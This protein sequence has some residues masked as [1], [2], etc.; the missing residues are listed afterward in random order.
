LQRRRA[1][2]HVRHRFELAVAFLFERRT[3]AAM[4]LVEVVVPVAVEFFEPVEFEV[5][6]LVVLQWRV[7][8][9]V[10]RWRLVRLTEFLFEFEERVL[11]QRLLD[12][13]LKVGDRQLQNFHRLDHARRQNLA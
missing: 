11:L 3:T 12:L 1:V 5:A 9:E 6:G 2:R 7:R 8:I 13:R 4:F 10:G